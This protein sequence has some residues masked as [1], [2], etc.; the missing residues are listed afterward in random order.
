MS[1]IGV[2]PLLAGMADTRRGIARTG[3]WNDEQGLLFGPI[4]GF[5]PLPNIRWWGDL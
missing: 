1:R 5:L 3:E 4:G 2:G